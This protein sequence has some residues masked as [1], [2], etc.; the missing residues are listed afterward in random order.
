MYAADIVPFYIDIN[1]WGYICVCIRLF[2]SISIFHVYA[3]VEWMHMCIFLHM[4]GHMCMWRTEVVAG[5]HS[6]LPSHLPYWDNI[7][8]WNP[9][10]VTCSVDP[11]SS[12]KVVRTQHWSSMPTLRGLY[13][14]MWVSS[15]LNLGLH[16]CITCVLTAESAP[17]PLFFS[18]KNTSWKGCKLPYLFLYSLFVAHFT[19]QFY[20]PLLKAWSII[21]TFTYG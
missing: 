8:H 21:S 14:F 20:S 10:L 18:S 1:L 9:E 5:N 4:C 3:C 2:F 13:G 17:C 15:Y 7:S 11:V 6:L 16:A 12:H 19:I